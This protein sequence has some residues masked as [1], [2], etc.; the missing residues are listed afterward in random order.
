M[1]LID[2]PDEVVA[3]AALRD[4][5][6]ILL[7]RLGGRLAVVSGRSLAQIDHILGDVAQGLALSGSH[8]CEH[9]WGGILAQPAR[10]ASL[11]RAAE[12][13]RTFIGARKG[14]L[15]EEKSFGVAL[16]YRLDETAEEGAQAI[17]AQLA[18]EF[19]L[20]LQHGK[21]MVEL[22]VAGG[23]KGRAVRR[24]MSRAPMAGTRPIFIGDDV[25]DETAFAAVKEL[26]GGG[27]LIGASRESA[28]IYNLAGPDELRRW[29]AEACA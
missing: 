25:T 26:G 19:D 18:E 17:A 4:L 6:N 24:M 21:L 20:E 16:H 27:I 10:P 8:G 14:V 22:R 29:L 9:R 23:D 28:A 3:D 5:L 11:D 13:L 7:D 2:R 15:L 12:R 1:H